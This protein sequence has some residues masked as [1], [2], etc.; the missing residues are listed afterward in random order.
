MYKMGV[1][2]FCMPAVIV[3]YKNEKALKLL[4]LTGLLF[5]ASVKYAL[6]HKVSPF[7]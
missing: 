3:K 7:T 4:V 6:N 2:R 1:N 5:C